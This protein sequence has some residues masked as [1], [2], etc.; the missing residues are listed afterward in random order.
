[1][2]LGFPAHI[3]CP[4]NTPQRCLRAGMNRTPTSISQT[5]RRQ[6]LRD[7]RDPKPLEPSQWDTNFSSQGAR[8]ALLQPGT[9]V[10][11]SLQRTHT[12]TLPHTRECEKIVAE[13]NLKEASSA[14]DPTTESG[15]LCPAL[16]GHPTPSCPPIMPITTPAGR[17]AVITAGYTWGML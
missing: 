7:P 4:L 3:P 9:V 14:L 16:Q 5:Q 11:G 8:T 2:G 12:P 15:K 1:M 10:P 13:K 6:E 17:G